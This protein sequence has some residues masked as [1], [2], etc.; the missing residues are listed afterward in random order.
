VSVGASGGGMQDTGSSYSTDNGQTWT[1][2]ESTIDHTALEVVSP[3]VA[4]SGS[5]NLSTLQGA[6]AN[7]L[8]TQ[9]LGTRR[10]AALQQALLVY[11]VPSHDGQFTLRLPAL[12]Q[13]GAEVRVHDAVG[14]EVYRKQLAASQLPIDLR[15]QP[16]GLYI[17]ELRTNN[18][19]AQHKL[20]IE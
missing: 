12:P 11:P 19:T 3:T 20:V 5:V 2:L 7:K 14:R 9:V 16:A 15:H 6:G 8:N 4:W 10:N 1:A 13:G 17:L 18:G